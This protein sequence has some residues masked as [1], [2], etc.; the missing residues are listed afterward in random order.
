MR[1]VVVTGIGMVSPLAPSAGESWSRLLNCE[2][3]IRQIVSFDVGDLASKVAGQ[4]P[5]EE[6][7]PGAPTLFN[8]LKYV[9]TK[10]LGRIDKFILFALASATDA[11]EDSGLNGNLSDE[12]KER[13]GVII[14]S[15]IGG[16]PAIYNTAIKLGSDG[17]RHISPFFIPSS[18]INLAS[19]HVSIRFGLKGPNHAVVTACASGT[20]A[21]GDAARMIKVGDADMMVAGGAEAAVCRLGVAGFSSARALTTHRNDNP[22]EASRPWDKSR[23]GFVISEGSGIVILEELEHAKK[24]GAK[25]YGELVGYGMSG[26]AYHMTAPCP[27]GDGAFR[28]M[29]NALRSA[30]INPD[31]IDYINAHG[32]ST[33]AG[34]IGELRAVERVLGNNSKASMSSTKS[35]VGHLLGAAGAVE[36]IFSLLSIKDQVAPATLNLHD[37]EETFLDLVPLQPRARKIDYVLSNS[38]GFGGTN[39]SLVFKKF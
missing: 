32:T 28:S 1:R 26:D 17:A 19:G 18:L 8:P 27:D 13:F 35:S 11:M 29:R 24:R 7:A 15:G 23:D 20:H 36:A 16:L 14:G 21:I 10:E 12:E 39:A 3:G 38:F 25:I 22:Q 37:S 34:D 9:T 30:Q 5:T 6:T 33:P 31:Q 4:V 2:S